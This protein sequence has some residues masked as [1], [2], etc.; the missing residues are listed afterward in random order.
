[1]IDEIK[2]VDKLNKMEQDYTDI[3]EH[4]PYVERVIHD[5]IYTIIPRCKDIDD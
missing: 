5:I 1:M 4:N 2:L 3:E